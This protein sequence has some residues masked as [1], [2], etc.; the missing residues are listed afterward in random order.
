MEIDAALLHKLR[1]MA[2]GSARPL[3]AT[4]ILRPLERPQGSPDS[5]AHR[6][7]AYAGA[8]RM[9]QTPEPLPRVPLS[10]CPDPVKLLSPTH[11]PGT[12]CMYVLCESQCFDL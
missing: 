3:A 5:S 11:P 8:S 10:V 2:G 12:V 9:M 4:A 6:R 7:L 1:R